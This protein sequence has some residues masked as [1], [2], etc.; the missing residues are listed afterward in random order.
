M[1]L[2]LWWRAGARAA[3]TPLSSSSLRPLVPPRLSGAPWV[4]HTSAAIC[5]GQGRPRR[6]P[7]SALPRPHS[8]SHVACSPAPPSRPAFPAARP[9]SSALRRAS[10][11]V[12]AA[13]LRARRPRPRRAEHRQALR[14]RAAS[15][16]RPPGSSLLTRPGPSL[17]VAVVSRGGRTG[18]RRRGWRREASCR[19]VGGGGGGAGRK[20][21]RDKGQEG[22]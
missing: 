21:A 9:V 13:R 2:W 6:A 17:S 4:P 22:G 15:A 16:Q 12:S 18:E 19:C 7:A 3:S 10:R 8:G 5:C 14:G 1:G 11:R 20:G